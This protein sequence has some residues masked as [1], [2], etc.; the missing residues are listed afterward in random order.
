MASWAAK[1]AFVAQIICIDALPSRLSAAPSGSPSLSARCG[2]RLRARRSCRRG[3]GRRLQ[4]PD[5]PA[6]SIGGR[7]RAGS[8]P[9]PRPDL[10]P[11]PRAAAGAGPPVGRGCATAFGDAAPPHAARRA[12][13]PVAGFRRDR[14]RLA[15]GNRRHAA[16]RAGARRPDP[17]QHHPA[18]HHRP[19]LGRGDRPRAAARFRHRPPGKPGPAR[20]D[21]R[22]AHAPQCDWRGALP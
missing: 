1:N 6:L 14:C 17:A 11:T 19:Q 4:H 13:H 3:R 8:R 5:F 2:R 21:R 12:N 7:R 20:A 18:R 22:H 10:P 9:A 16:L 15:M